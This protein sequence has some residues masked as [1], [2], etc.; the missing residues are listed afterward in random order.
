MTDHGALEAETARRRVVSA[1]RRAFWWTFALVGCLGVLWALASPVLSVPDETAHVYK[2]IAQ[3]RGQVIGEEV[4]GVKH[5]V[6]DVPAGDEFHPE[7]ICYVYQ[8]SRPASCP[9]EMGTE[10]GEDWFATH[11]GAYN[12]IYY[13]AVGWPSLLLTGSPAVY[14]MR[15]VSALLG[16]ALIAWAMRAAVASRNAWMPLAVAFA[17][18][19]MNVYLMG[20]VNPNGLEIA[21][22]AAL[23]VG[24]LCLFRTYEADPPPIGRAGLW[25]MVVVAAIAL[26]NA[27]ALGPLWVA[28]VV[29]LAAFAA[30]WK[31]FRAFATDRRN[32]L[33]VVLIA[34]GGAFSLIWTF[35]GG[36]LSSQAAADDAPLVGAGFLAGLS[37]FLRATPDYL[38]QAAGWFGWL[39][40]PLPTTAYWLLIASIAV[41]VV[42]A[43]AGGSTRSTWVLVATAAAAILV[44][45][46]VQARSVA[47]TGIIWQGRYG[48]VLYLGVVIVAAFLIA[49]HERL[50]LDLLAPRISAWAGGLLAA[51][52]VAAFGYALYRYVVG[53]GAPYAAMVRAPQWQPP[54]GWPALLIAYALV[55]GVFVFVVARASRAARPVPTDAR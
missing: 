5:L 30:G 39:D 48:I 11:V 19:P 32:I 31:P 20:S 10:F 50:D 17:A 46:L 21:A 55:A 45:A 9:L 13:Y 12:P 43:L 7:V 40:T 26:A 41:L 54:L 6:V 8:S 33:P 35:L 34:V 25:G 23:W 29:V 14:A 38:Q 24:V 16:A 42:I 28:V 49:R 47:Q 3:L 2:A 1:A 4:P 53:I 51:F 36:S 44:P 27:R 18:A 52:G 15:I 37:Y 22:A